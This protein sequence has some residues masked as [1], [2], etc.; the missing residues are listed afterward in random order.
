MKSI[1][2]LSKALMIFGILAMI[3][4]CSL[5]QSED[6]VDV[7]ETSSAPASNFNKDELTG[8]VEIDGSSTVY[9]ISE[10]VAEEFSKEYKNVRV[11]VGVSGTGG[12]FKRFT[13]GETDISD[14]SRL[15]KDKEAAKATENNIEFYEL[16]LGDDGL[17]VMVNPNNDFVDCLTIAELKM[18]WEPGSTINNWNQVRS[19]FPAEKIRLYGPD[20]DSGTFDYFTEAINGEAQASRPDYTASADDNVL[21]S[22]IAGDKY[23]LGYFG[24]AFFIENQDK[25]KLVAIDAGDGCI[26]PTSETIKDGSYKPLARPLF[27]Y[28]SASSY[29]TKP[30]VK[31][32]VDFYMKHGPELT[33]EVGYVSSEPSVY[34]NNVSLLKK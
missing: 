21:V 7:I 34:V 6:S 5:F 3:A 10:A 14:A 11:N 19:T 13:N 30:Q 1:I 33:A 22:G 12:G 2:K 25:L 8:V 20:T 24:Y 26:N 23:A 32:F 9:P 15:I 28:V 17:S 16:R 4:G 27:I 31:T 29:A 18:I